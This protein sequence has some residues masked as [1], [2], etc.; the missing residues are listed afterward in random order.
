MVK[1]RKSKAERATELR[2][3]GDLTAQGA[4]TASPGHQLNV[5]KAAETIIQFAS[6]MAKKVDEP[7][8]VLLPSNATQKE[9][10]VARARQAVRRGQEVYLPI[11]SSVAHALPDAFL[12]SALFS[13]SSGIQ[14]QNDS[15]LAGDQSLLVANKEVVTLS[16][17]NLVFS[18]Y[19]LCQ[20]DRQVYATCLEYYRDRPLA[21]EGSTQ[22]IR[23]T[24]H[25]F[26]QQM[27]GTHNAKTY[28]AIRASL[29]RLSFARLHLRYG[30]LDIVVP[31]LLSVTFEDG[32]PSGEMHGRDLLLLRITE[33]VAELFGKA[34]WSAVDKAASDYDG[35]RG[36]LA[37]FYASHSRARWLPVETL[38]RLSG[39]ESRFDNFRSSLIKA[40]DKLMSPETPGCSRVEQYVFSKD[41]TRLYVV[42]VG[43]A[44]VNGGDFT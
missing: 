19:P 12:R 29:L 39:Y 25:E 37:N 24:F 27:R 5:L 34:R 23:T 21:P 22:H 18:G 16:D 33:P 3:L 43:W 41:K 32:G 35:L 9:L 26:A 8:V 36:W 15:V 28:L 44:T 42:R 20:F 14:K 2:Q 38:Y 4:M 6:N 13:A 31:N 40:L 11:W 7:A 1:R 30:G 17:L 10:G